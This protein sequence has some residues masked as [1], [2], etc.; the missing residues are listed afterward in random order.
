MKYWIDFFCDC[1]SMCTAWHTS[2]LQNIALTSVCCLWEFPIL[3]LSRRVLCRIAL[4]Q[5]LFLIAW[6]L[7]AGN[8]DRTYV[9]IRWFDVRSTFENV[10]LTAQSLLVTLL[11]RARSVSRLLLLGSNVHFCLWLLRDKSGST[12]LSLVGI[13]FVLHLLICR[14]LQSRILVECWDHSSS[15]SL[16]IKSVGCR[17]WCPIDPFCMW[18]KTILLLLLYR[19]EWPLVCVSCDPPCI[20]WMYWLEF[21]GYAL[22]DKIDAW[23][24]LGVFRRLFVTQESM[25]PH[26]IERPECL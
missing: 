7:S 20:P 16:S 24:Y 10:N 26:F 18:I 12:S 11:R 19:L 23:V 22:C 17:T 14:D 3:C 2:V 1:L 5:F 21:I 8:S 13:D 25:H 15:S 9:S 6:W 4:R